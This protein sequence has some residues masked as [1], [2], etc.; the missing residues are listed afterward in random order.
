VENAVKHGIDRYDPESCVVLATY[1][2]GDAVCIEV[3]DSGKGFDLNDET[4][5]KGGIGLKNARVRLEQLCGGS[6]DICR[7]N[8]W[9]V[10]R[11]RLP[12]GAESTTD[13]A[14]G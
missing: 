2:D 3:R 9:T 6:L 8:G 7:E 11:I 5:G 13:P 12:G 14:D 1:P 10:I 4:L